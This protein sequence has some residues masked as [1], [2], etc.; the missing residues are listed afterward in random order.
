[1]IMGRAIKSILK[2]PYFAADYIVLFLMLSIGKALVL[3]SV[4]DLN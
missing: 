2:A 4:I 3:T 1:M